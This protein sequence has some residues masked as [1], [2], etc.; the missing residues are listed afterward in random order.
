LTIL[1]LNGWRRTDVFLT[2]RYAE[3]SAEGR[4][5]FGGFGWWVGGFGGIMGHESLKP[6][7]RTNDEWRM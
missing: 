7:Q 6:W 4:R 2:Q 3:V 5:G 1:E